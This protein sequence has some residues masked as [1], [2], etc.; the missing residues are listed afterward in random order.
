MPLFDV[1]KQYLSDALL[2]FGKF[3]S[4]WIGKFI[5]LVLTFI[6]VILLSLH[7]MKSFNV[8]GAD[9]TMTQRT[10]VD[11]PIEGVIDDEEVDAISSD[12]IEKASTPESVS[13]QV[14]V[15]DH[16]SDHDDEFADVDDDDDPEDMDV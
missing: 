14:A 6:I 15:S 1:V 12:L 11:S 10:E 8:T 9:S 7:G 4:S 2:V 13:K 16:D 3:A 5:M